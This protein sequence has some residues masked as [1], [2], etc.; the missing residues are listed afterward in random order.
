[1]LS[2]RVVSLWFIGLF[3]LFFPKYDS[4]DSCVSCL[5]LCI[6]SKGSS[7]IQ[8]H[9][10]TWGLPTYPIRFTE[11]RWRRALSSLSWWSVSAWLLPYQ[12]LQHFLYVVF[13]SAR[14]ETSV[15]RKTVVAWQEVLTFVECIFCL[16]PTLGI[17]RLTFCCR[18]GNYY[19]VCPLICIFWML[20]CR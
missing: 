18:T 4:F 17:G 7:P 5:F 3:G 13:A 14:D 12:T 2:Q 20:H 1:M 19:R 8:R 6:H 15:E 16:S 11:N 9:R 10:D